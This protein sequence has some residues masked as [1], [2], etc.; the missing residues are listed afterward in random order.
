MAR[1]ARGRITPHRFLVTSSVHIGKPQYCPLASIGAYETQHP[2]LN[3]AVHDVK[4][5]VEQAQ[6]DQLLPLPSIRTMELHIT[7][8]HYCF[9]NANSKLRMR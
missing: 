4:L 5:A 6:L 8:Q 7:K 3:L 9:I 2:F 1:R